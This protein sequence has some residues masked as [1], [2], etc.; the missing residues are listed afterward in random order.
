MLWP[1][2]GNAF[3]GTP[4]LDLKVKVEQVQVKK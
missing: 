4:E 2:Y 1:S 3:A